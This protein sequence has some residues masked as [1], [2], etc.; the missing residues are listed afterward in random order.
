MRI[1]DRVNELLKVRV[2]VFIVAEILT[3]VYCY[4]C[5]C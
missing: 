2:V 4:H 3:E 5:Y 1:F